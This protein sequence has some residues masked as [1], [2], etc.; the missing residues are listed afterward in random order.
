VAK[1]FAIDERD[2]INMCCFSSLMHPLCNCGPTQICHHSEAEAPA[3]EAG[4]IPAPP[5]PSATL[6]PPVKPKS[7]A[8]AACRSCATPRTP[9][10]KPLHL[11]AI[12]APSPSPPPC[13]KLRM[14]SP[15]VAPV[16]QVTVAL[17]TQSVVTPARLVASADL[18]SPPFAS[19][20]CTSFLEMMTVD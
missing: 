15:S 20:K 16:R 18:R 11:E 8:A 17:P 3:G 10:A 12:V 14:Q 9:P 19:R 5:R 13:P 4:A 1:H 6:S 7:K 2:D